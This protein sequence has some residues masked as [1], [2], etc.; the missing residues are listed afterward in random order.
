M[1]ALQAWLARLAWLWKSRFHFHGGL[2]L[3]DD[4][5]NAHALLSE[6]ALN[7]PISLF[8]YVVASSSA[9]ASFQSLSVALKNRNISYSSKVRATPRRF[10]KTVLTLVERFPSRA[11]H[12]CKATMKTTL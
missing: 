12:A 1:V 3:Q 8:D 6:L 4:H 11:S 10:L 2:L 7:C 9:C 5:A